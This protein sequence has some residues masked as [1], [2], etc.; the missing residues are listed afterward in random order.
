M[1]L[2]SPISPFEHL[3][4][5]F[6]DVEDHGKE[7]KVHGDLVFPEV[8]KTAVC[9]IGLHLSED[10]FRFDAPP[11]PMLDSLLGCQKSSGFPLVFVEPVIDLDGS[12]FT[13]GFIAE[14]SQRTTLAVLC[15]V[16]CA[17]GDIVAYRLSM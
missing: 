7:C 9:H 1:R 16:A 3:C 6:L 2:T 13:P 4:A 12:P 15:P 5:H 8:S 11:S 10:S 14:A 17:L